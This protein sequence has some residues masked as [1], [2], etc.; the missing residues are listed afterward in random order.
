MLV[1]NLRQAGLRTG[2]PEREGGE[3]DVSER[4][5][6]FFGGVCTGSS[7]R[8]AVNPA[9]LVRCVC[10]LSVVVWVTEV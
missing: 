10:R 5:A 7:G 6:M 3:Q 1:V 8:F 4:E 9:L 2:I